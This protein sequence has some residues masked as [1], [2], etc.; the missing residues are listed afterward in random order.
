MQK[1]DGH[2]GPCGTRLRSDSPTASPPSRRCGTI[3][4]FPAPTKTA[5]YAPATPGMSSG[6]LEILLY[7]L[8]RR[9]VRAIAGETC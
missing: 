9:R 4:T 5:H 3:G 7:I 6:R 1:N 8:H 2:G